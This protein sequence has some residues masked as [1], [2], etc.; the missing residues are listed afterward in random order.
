MHWIMQFRK[1]VYILLFTFSNNFL[2]PTSELETIDDDAEKSNI[3]FVKI[4]DKRFGK[5]FGIKKFPALSFFRERNIVLYT[6]DLKVIIYC[7]SLFLRDCSMRFFN[8]VFLHKSK[9]PGPQSK[10]LKYFRK[11]FRFSRRY[12]RNQFF[13]VAISG[14]RYPEIN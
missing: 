12:S 9:V 1:L 13:F 10:I 14:A 3:K 5:S 6:G 4:N 11:Y 7:T 8:S 2:V